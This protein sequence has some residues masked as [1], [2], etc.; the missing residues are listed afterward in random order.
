LSARAKLLIMITL[1]A[2]SWLIILLSIVVVWRAIASL[3]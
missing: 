1:S 3:I 2:V